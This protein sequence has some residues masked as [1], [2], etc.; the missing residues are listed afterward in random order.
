[1]FYQLIYCNL[2]LKNINLR[3]QKRDIQYTKKKRETYKNNK[4]K[5]H[6]IT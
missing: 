5:P 4:N 6:E 1:M 3:K 2:K